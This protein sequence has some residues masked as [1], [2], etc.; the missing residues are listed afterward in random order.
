MAKKAYIVLKLGQNMYFDTN[1]HFFAKKN[2]FPQ[3]SPIF[4]GFP[5][6]PILPF[7]CRFLNDDYRKLA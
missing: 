1:V 6:M 7:C 3:I 5:I 4:Q 2:K